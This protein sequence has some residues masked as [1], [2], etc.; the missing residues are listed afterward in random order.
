MISSFMTKI[1]RQFL[2]RLSLE[3]SFKR[4]PGTVCGGLCSDYSLARPIK[5]IVSFVSA[6]ILSVTV[7]CLPPHLMNLSTP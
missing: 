2:L 7:I 6:V 1:L 4:F 5:L 3:K